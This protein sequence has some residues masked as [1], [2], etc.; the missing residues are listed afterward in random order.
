MAK[1][2]KTPFRIVG[3]DGEWFAYSVAVGL[4]SWGLRVRR[5]VIRT[6]GGWMKIYATQGRTPIEAL[7]RL[8]RRLG[9][10]R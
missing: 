6:P 9:G 8:K 3:G 1:R 2:G 7:E 10:V 4:P 5:I